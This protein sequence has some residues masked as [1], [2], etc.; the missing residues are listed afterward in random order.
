MTSK[1][2]GARW[3]GGAKEDVQMGGVECA[4]CA[5]NNCVMWNMGD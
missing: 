5:R 3:Y 4:A 2:K 1:N